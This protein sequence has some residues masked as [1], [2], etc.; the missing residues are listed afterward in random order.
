MSVR[1]DNVRSDC[2]GC[3]IAT[4][5][6]IGA[7]GAAYIAAGMQSCPNITSLNLGG[8]DCCVLCCM[9]WAHECVCVI[10]PVCMLIQC[11]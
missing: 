4:G 10:V 5:N 2:A 7:E 1:A 9:R 8:K 6:D 11:V 3:V